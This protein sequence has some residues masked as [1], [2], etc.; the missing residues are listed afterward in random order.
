[1]TEW[2]DIGSS[3]PGESC[4][5]VGSG[6]Y[7]PRARR[8]C[9]AYIALLRRVLGTEPTGANLSIKSRPH[10]F[11][12]Y[13]SVVCKFDLDDKVAVEFA[14]R[15]ERDGPEEWDEQARAELATQKEVGHGNLD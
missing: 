9:R 4:A 15:C 3:P 5:Q 12:N 13:L 1:M 7:Y 11:G 10:D 8:E 6:D 2:L 14:Y